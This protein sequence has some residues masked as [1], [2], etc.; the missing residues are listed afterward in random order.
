MNLQQYINESERTYHYRIKTVVEL[1]DDA[2]DRLERVLMKHCPVDV[3]RPRKTMLQKHPM[4]FTTVDAAEV[5]IVDVEL[6]VPASPYVLHKELCKSMGVNGDHLNVR[7]YNEP[8]EIEN[9]RLAAATEMDEEA[10]AAGLEHTS[11]LLDPNYENGEEP[12]ELAGDG[13]TK[14]FLSYLR[15][16]QEEKPTQKKVDAPHPLSV[17]KDQPK[18]ET[19]DEGDYNANIEGAPTIGKAGEGPDVETSNQGNLTDRKRTYKRQYGKDGSTKMLKRDVDTQK[20]P[21]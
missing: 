3:S 8:S 1:G 13:Y 21:K 4:D 15:K 10:S 20:D 14:K 18:Q 7:G 9:E 11:V 6:G 12:Q 16:V 17:W 2:M 5:Y 19:T